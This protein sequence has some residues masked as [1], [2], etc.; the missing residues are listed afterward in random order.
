[1][2]PLFYQEIPPVEPDASALNTFS[3]TSADGS[4]QVLDVYSPPAVESQALPLVIAPHPITWT[5]RQDYH[6]GLAGLNRVYHRGYTNLAPKYG[7][8]IAM[9]HGHHRAV[10]NASLANP[11]HI[12]DLAGIPRTLESHGFPVDRRRIYTCGLSMGG[13]EALALAG[14]H[15]ELVAAAVGFNPIVDLAAWQEDME[16]SPLP[17][18]KEFKTAS[19]I[20]QEVGGKPLDVP[21]LY[22]E[23]SVFPYARNLTGV[24]TLIFWSG[25]DIIVPRQQESHAY[26]LYQQVKSIDP[27]SP[28]VEYNHTYIHGKLEFDIKTRWMLHEWCD[29]EWALQ[30][31]LQH[32]K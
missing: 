20:A 10:E 27:N 11:P 22:S 2:E 9:P 25:Q 13:Q 12:Q 5:A 31:L 24:P 29:Y 26:K 15:P 6:G 30:W 4:T 7:V 28:I 17:E 14:K 21:T 1:M 16:A 3:F 18:I 23:R 19:N 32:Q 8:L